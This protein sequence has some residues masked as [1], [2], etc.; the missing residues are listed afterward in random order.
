M[1][2]ILCRLS[3]ADNTAGQHSLSAWTFAWPPLEHLSAT[4]QAA[5]WGLGTKMN[6]AS[7]FSFGA[8][9]S[10]TWVGTQRCGHGCLLARAIKRRAESSSLLEGGACLG[11][12]VVS[13]RWR[14][15]RAWKASEGQEHAGIKSFRKLP[16]SGWGVTLRLRTCAVRG[17][18]GW[19]LCRLDGGPR[20]PNSQ[21]SQDRQLRRSWKEKQGGAK[22]NPIRIFCL[23]LSLMEAPC[24]VPVSPFDIYKGALELSVLGPPHPTTPS[25][26]WQLAQPSPQDPPK[27]T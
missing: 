21:C 13:Q 6:K 8:R 25:A 27:A 9:S 3:L 4:C 11:S 5:C 10:Q 12:W 17:A 16:H 7:Q 19:C 24:W 22:D 20:T 23:P 14:F 18:V 26:F 1:F 2:T 15:N